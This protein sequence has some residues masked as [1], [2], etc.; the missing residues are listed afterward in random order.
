MKRYGWDPVVKQFDGHGG[1]EKGSTP[2][3]QA[4]NKA[5]DMAQRLIDTRYLQ[6]HPGDIP[7]IYT[8]D[9][10]NHVLGQNGNPGNGLISY[11]GK[12]HGMD[13][14]N[15]HGEEWLKAGNGEY[16]LRDESGYV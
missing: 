14:Y 6:R 16:I 13:E 12:L 4:V 5:I 1:I 15:S 9:S 11:R 2:T 3:E 10:K 8:S 7:F